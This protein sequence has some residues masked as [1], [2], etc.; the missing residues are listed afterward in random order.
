M[1]DK[2][3]PLFTTPAFCLIRPVNFP[4]NPLRRRYLVRAHNQQIVADIKHG[5][6]KQNV[7]Q[8]VFLEEGRREVFEV[9]NQGVI[10]PRPVHG[11]IEA[12][13]IPLCGI[14]KVTGVRPV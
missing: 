2:T 3:A 10:R 11:E 6:I 1:P 5:V 14:G 8:S 4:Q 12:V 9:F 7:Q 13:F